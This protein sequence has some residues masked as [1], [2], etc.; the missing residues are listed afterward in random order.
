MVLIIKKLMD[1]GMDMGME[2]EFEKSKKKNW[3]KFNT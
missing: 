3:W 1:M 2:Q